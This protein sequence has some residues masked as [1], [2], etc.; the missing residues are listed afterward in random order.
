MNILLYSLFVFVGFLFVSKELTQKRSRRSYLFFLCLIFLLTICSRIGH[1][2]EYNDLNFY[3]TYFLNDD[4]KYFEPG[5]VVFVTFVKLLFGYNPYALIFFVGLFEILFLYL[6]YKILLSGS[7]YYDTKGINRNGYGVFTANNGRINTEQAVSKEIV[8]LKR[9][10]AQTIR[11]VI[12]RRDIR[13]KG[14]VSVRVRNYGFITLFFVYALY[15]GSSFGCEVIRL[16]MALCILSCSIAAILTKRPL[17]ALLFFPLAFSFQYTSLGLI[18]AV[19]FFMVFK[20]PSVR[21]LWF[22]LLLG[23]LID[24]CFVSGILTTSLGDHLLG[25]VLSIGDIFSHYDSYSGLESSSSTRSLQYWAY[26]LFGV[27]MLFG[28]LSDHR[29]N[30]AVTIYIMG[31]FVGSLF[32]GSVFSMRLQWLFL[33]VIIFVLFFFL[34]DS[35]FP[36]KTRLSVLF[37]YSVIEVVMAIRYLGCYVY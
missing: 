13:G 21:T 4:D 11:L 19:F 33:P 16:G 7:R 5:Y 22:I 23:M 34:K 12:R 28:N 9:N 2:Q 37:F 26:H 30:R 18:V 17:L 1:D 32:N 29:F 24:Q 35:R 8:P 36:I 31:L 6:A 25:K 27:L 15:W 20:E 10:T 14:V 3:I